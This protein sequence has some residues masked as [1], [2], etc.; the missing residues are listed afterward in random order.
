M[1][2]C[3]SE[4]NLPHV[5]HAH[6]PLDIASGQPEIGGGCRV[7][8]GRNDIRPFLWYSNNLWLDLCCIFWLGEAVV[9]PPV[10]AQHEEDSQHS[11]GFVQ[12]HHAA[13]QQIQQADLGVGNCGRDNPEWYED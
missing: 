10:F 3:P 9:V 1:I 4:A 13:N 5:L 2:P 6:V 12:V 8:D 7:L 11:G